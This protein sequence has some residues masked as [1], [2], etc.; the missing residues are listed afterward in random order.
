MKRNFEFFISAS[1]VLFSTSLIQ[2]LT[3]IFITY[4]F[5]NYK[6]SQKLLSKTIKFIV[7]IYSLI[8]YI[9]IHQVSYFIMLDLEKKISIFH[10]IEE[11]LG[12]MRI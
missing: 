8:K 5:P 12:K 4:C 9:Y 3:L 6:N 11:N 10:T 1:T 7:Y 2:F